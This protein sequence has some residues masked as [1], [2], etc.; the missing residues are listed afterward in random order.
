[1]TKPKTKGELALLAASKKKSQFVT[2]IT[3]K[4]CLWIMAPHA[5]CGYKTGENSYFCNDHQIEADAGKLLRA[6]IAKAEN[7]S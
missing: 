2:P 7:T 6:E 1:M 3:T 4:H 5:R